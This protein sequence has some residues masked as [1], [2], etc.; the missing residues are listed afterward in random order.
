MPTSAPCSQTTSSPASSACGWTVGSWSRRPDLANPAGGE[1]DQN[2]LQID[3]PAAWDAG[4]SGAGT[5]VAVLDSGID[6]SHPDLVGKVTAA[7]DFTGSGSTTDH[8]GTGTHTAALIAGTGAAADG[9]RKGVAFGADLLSAKVVDDDGQARESWIMAGLEWAADQ[10]ADVIHV[11][12]FAYPGPEADA[13]TAAVEDLVQST[14]IPVVVPAGDVFFSEPYTIF[15]PGPARHA[16]TVGAV[17]GADALA[18][19]SGR[20]PTFDYGL[21]PDLLAPGAEI[22]SAVPGSELYAMRSGTAAAAAHVSGAVAL[23]AERHPEWGAEALRAAVVTGAVTL[24]GVSRYDQGGGRLDLGA[25]TA[26]PVGITPAVLDFGRLEYPHDEGAEQ[27]IVL[28]NPGDDDVRVRLDLDLAGPDGG[29]A[30]DG[31]AELTDARPGRAGRRERHH[32]DASR[33]AQPRRGA[34]RPVRGHGRVGRW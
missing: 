16:L 2:L 30:P 4:L 1:L 29:P 6:E 17:D 31:L 34:E 33:A 20:G 28:T 10:G 22:I 27:E 8:F 21:K 9:A 32:H 12:V 15:S 24:D 19:F 14:D 11:G 18:G 25:T 5:T 26:A 13:L 7:D 23:V 3:A